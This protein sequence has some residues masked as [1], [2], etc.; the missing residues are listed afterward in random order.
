M[1]SKQEGTWILFDRKEQGEN[2]YGKYLAVYS[3]DKSIHY[4]SDS[5]LWSVFDTAER[6]QPFL[7]TYDGKK[8]T[9]VQDVKNEILKTGT[10]KALRKLIELDEGTRLRSQAISYAKDL[11]VARIMSNNN[12]VD[13]NVIVQQVSM[14]D[15]AQEIYEFIKGG[16]TNGK[17][18]PTNEI[19]EDTIQ[20]RD[21]KPT[22]KKGKST[23][24]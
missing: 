1:A 16:E 13:A 11:K 24:V 2:Q 5:K 15:E 20:D 8:V 17:T 9:H 10:V 14:Y 12:I 21:K 6:W 22:S 18:E 19:Q 3:L 4:I 23:Q 7:L